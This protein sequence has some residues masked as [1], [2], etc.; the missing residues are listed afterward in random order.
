M[1]AC[2]TRAPSVRNSGYGAACGMRASCVTLTHSSLFFL[3]VKFRPNYATRL[4]AS[5]HARARSCQ[6]RCFRSVW[7]YLRVCPAKLKDRGDS[8]GPSITPD[9]WQSDVSH[10]D[11]LLHHAP[12]PPRP[13]HSC[14]SL[15]VR[16]V[17]R[18]RE[19]SYS[20][21]EI[22]ESGDAVSRRMYVRVR[23]PA[24]CELL[25]DTHHSARCRGAR[26]RRQRRLIGIRSGRP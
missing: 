5:T 16:L 14:A 25:A 23:P 1:N 24:N 2:G 17:C 19:C 20:P 3:L 15:R 18:S 11:R 10:P 4:P 8:G 22:G 21:S 13:T 12:L 26:V 6:R 7:R 9:A